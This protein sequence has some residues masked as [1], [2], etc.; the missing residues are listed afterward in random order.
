MRKPWWCLYNEEALTRCCL[1][2]NQ[3]LRLKLLELFEVLIG[4]VMQLVTATQKLLVQGTV[5][6][7]QSI[8]NLP[9]NK[10]A[11]QWK[12]IIDLLCLNQEEGHAK[13]GKIIRFIC[14]DQLWFSIVRL[15]CCKTSAISIHLFWK[16]RKMCSKVY[17][18]LC[19]QTEH[20]FNF[21]FRSF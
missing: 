19:F 17:L 5:S 8:S 4:L 14:G 16:V 13:A 6:A 2:T 18:Q 7:T 10:Q 1:H 20:A 11:E 12:T 3:S 21:H 15:A 9:C